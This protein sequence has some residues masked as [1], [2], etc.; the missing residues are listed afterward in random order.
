MQHRRCVR[1]MGP[2]IGRA[3]RRQEVRWVRVRDVRAGAGGVGVEWRGGEARLMKQVKEM[4]LRMLW[5]RWVSVSVVEVDVEVVVEE[6]EMVAAELDGGGLAV[7]SP[8]GVGMPR[9]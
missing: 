4:R 9:M 3:S 7:F 5:L 8:C 1:W 6:A 2:S